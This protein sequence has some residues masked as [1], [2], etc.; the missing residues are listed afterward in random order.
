MHDGQGHQ[1][2]VFDSF[3]SVTEQGLVFVE[4][5][6]KHGCGDAFVSVVEAVVLCHKVQQICF[7]IRITSPGCLMRF[8]L[9]A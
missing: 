7:I 8:R 1:R 2:R 4:K 9:T 6:E 5:V 3:P